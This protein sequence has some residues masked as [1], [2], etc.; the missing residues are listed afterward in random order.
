MQTAEHDKTQI[1]VYVAEAPKD[2]FTEKYTAEWQQWGGQ[3]ETTRKADGYKPQDFST[4]HI[5]GTHHAD[6]SSP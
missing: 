6:R 3:K 4:I 5:E 2:Q 1:T